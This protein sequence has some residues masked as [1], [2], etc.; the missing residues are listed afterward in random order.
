MLSL[1]KPPPPPQ[2]FNL[3]N[4]PQDAPLQLQPKPDTPLQPKPD[5]PGPL[6]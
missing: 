5:T 4:S 3:I 2:D 1:S 6:P